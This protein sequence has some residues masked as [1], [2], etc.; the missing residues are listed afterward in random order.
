M[1]RESAM[2]VGLVTAFCLLLGVVAGVAIG[3][4][5]KPLPPATATLPVASPTTPTP[6]KLGAPVS[7]LALGVNS[8]TALHP[9]LEGCWVITFEPGLP[10]YYLLG[11]SPATLVEVQGATNAR[12]LRDVYDMDLQIGRGTVFTHDALKSISPG[13]PLPQYEV[14]FDRQML[15]QAV[16]SLNGIPLNG[17]WLDGDALLTRYDAIPVDQAI[18]QLAFQRAALEAILKTAQQRDWS[19][20][21]WQA[22]LN[23]GQQWQP[24]VQAFMTLAEIALP[25]ASQAE[26]YINLAPL[27]PEATASP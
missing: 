4:A 2:L 20:N 16:N 10:Q 27:A 25:T 21:A 23:L 9:Q 1:S 15:A 19:S 8:A 14:V 3:N 7:V 18:D 13:L 12:T 26:F 11:Y 5:G 22:Y 6:I 17:E 24:D